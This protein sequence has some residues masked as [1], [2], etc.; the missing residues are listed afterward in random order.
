MLQK[1]Q[2]QPSIAHP[3]LPRRRRAPEKFEIGSGTPYFP[4]TPKDLYRKVYLEALDLI[5]AFIGERFSEPS[6][7]A[8]KH[9][10]TLLIG[11]LKSEDISLHMEYLKE[12][13]PGGTK[14]E[15]LSAQLDIF[16]ELMKKVS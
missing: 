15:K 5:I 6:F 13:Y 12:N 10:E 1:K 14:I 8:Y 7:A 16:K 4:E 11:F 2:F 3:E 9:I